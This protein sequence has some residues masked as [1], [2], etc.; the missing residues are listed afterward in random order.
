MSTFCLE[1]FMSDRDARSVPFLRFLFAGILL[2]VAL[3]GFF[4]AR[5]DHYVTAIP[6]E[7][8][9]QRA[10]VAPPAYL[11]G[12]SLSARDGAVILALTAV[13]IA[14]L[15]GRYWISCAGFAAGAAA[16]N[17]ALGTIA[18]EIAGNL[19]PLGIASLLLLTLVP[20]GIGSGFGA[21]MRTWTI[22]TRPRLTPP[23]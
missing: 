18:G 5:W 4:V 14:L 1:S 15:A 10:G 13:A 7:R 19:W 21:V 23:S 17:V 6:A 9:R 8:M 12:T 11:A 22:R 16:G 3:H 20:I 2:S